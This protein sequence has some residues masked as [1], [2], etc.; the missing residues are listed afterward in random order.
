MN[1]RG[2]VTE[3]CT[4]TCA[5]QNPCC[6]RTFAHTPQASSP[7]TPTHAARCAPLPGSPI[8]PQIVAIDGIKRGSYDHRRD[9]GGAFAVAGHP[10]NRPRSGNSRVRSV[11][12][13]GDDDGQPFETGR[14]TRLSIASENGG[15]VLA[16]LPSSLYFFCMHFIVVELSF[17]IRD[18]GRWHVIV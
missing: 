1:D 6:S 3:R 7:I 14:I 4:A 2:G 5:S 8:R 16:L 18:T 17:V 12:K 13:G 15:F 11:G 9:R 10:Q